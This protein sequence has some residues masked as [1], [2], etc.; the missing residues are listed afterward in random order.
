METYK[1]YQSIY[2]EYNQN[3]QGDLSLALFMIKLLNVEK[4][5]SLFKD[6]YKFIKYLESDK[7]LKLRYYLQVD[8][9]NELDDI[10]IESD[11]CIKD[12]VNHL[13]ELFGYT[14]TRPCG[15]L[16]YYYSCTKI[17]ENRQELYDK[18]LSDIVNQQQ[19]DDK[20]TFEKWLNNV[21]TLYNNGISKESRCN[22][23]LDR[24]KTRIN[25]K[26]PINT[27]KNNLR[28]IIQFNDKESV[29]KLLYSMRDVYILGL[30]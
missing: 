17:P 15:S 21:D 29:D 27:L 14:G 2:N 3:L 26:Y 9:W 7:P 5:Y 28:R 11:K 10:L 4:E 23:V 12:E 20:D 25:L 16:H 19:K 1:H 30:V 22:V 13:N 18:Y 24:I 6:Q 8:F